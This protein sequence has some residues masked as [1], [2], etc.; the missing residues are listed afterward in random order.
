[1]AFNYNSKDASSALPEGKYPASLATCEEGTSKSSGCPMLTLTFKVYTDKGGERTV[2][3]Y[4]VNPSTL[5]KMKRLAKA[6][7]KDAEFKAN[8]FQPADNIGAN[9]TLELSMEEDDQYGDKNGVRGYEPS[10]L[11]STSRVSP[12]KGPVTAGTAGYEPIQEEDIPF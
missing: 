9:L 1:M 6:L 8:T 12:P 5:W 11:G 2:Y 3:D 10:T 4:I 7:G